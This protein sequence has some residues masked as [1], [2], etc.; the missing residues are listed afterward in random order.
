MLPSCPQ[1]CPGP[2][3]FYVGMEEPTAKGWSPGTLALTHSEKQLPTGREK[4]LSLRTSW[5]MLT[6]GPVH[7]FPNSMATPPGYSD[8]QVAPS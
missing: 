4:A 5:R 8:Y 3:D 2:W 6:P 7:T 1:V